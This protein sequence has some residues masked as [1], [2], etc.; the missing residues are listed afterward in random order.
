M[1][2][3]DVLGLAGSLIIAVA[4]FANLQDLLRSEGWFYSLANLI[5]ASL[6]LLSLW[7]KWNLPAAVMEGFWAAISL[8][9]L[10]RAI[11]QSR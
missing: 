9:G 10:A 1:S 7:F 6:I 4:Y 3:I 2:L 11:K 8:Y 5:G